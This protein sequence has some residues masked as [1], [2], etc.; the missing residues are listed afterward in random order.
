MQSQYVDSALAYNA[1]GE[2]YSLSLSR[3]LPVWDL[4]TGVSYGGSSNK[5]TASVSKELMDNLTCIVDTSRSTRDQTG[6]E[7]VKFFYGLRF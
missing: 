7:A 2:R 3:G 1:N 4:K 5:V 6:E